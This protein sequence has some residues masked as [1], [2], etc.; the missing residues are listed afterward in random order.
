MEIKK[1][2]LKEFH[3]KIDSLHSV[4]TLLLECWGG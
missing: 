3:R 1:E 4:K 2:V